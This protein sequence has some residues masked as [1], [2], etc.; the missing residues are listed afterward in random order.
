MCVCMPA[1]MCVHERVCVVLMGAGTM[2]EKQTFLVVL[3]GKKYGEQLVILYFMSVLAPVLLI[4]YTCSNLLC[5]LQHG[6]TEKKKT[7]NN[8]LDLSG[9][10]NYV[11][12]H[13]ISQVFFSFFFFLPTIAY[14]VNLY[15]FKCYRN[16]PKV[17]DR[18]AWANSADPDKTAPRGAV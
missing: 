1:C 13:P 11:L 5:Y 6:D 10:R 17:S 9:M 4:R 15:S 8:C 18:F 14:I 16:D 3:L 2:H 12:P 7:E